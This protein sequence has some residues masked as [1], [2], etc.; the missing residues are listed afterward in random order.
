MSM[1]LYDFL[2]LTSNERLMHRYKVYLRSSTFK[3]KV[4]RLMS[5]MKC[6]DE[7][8]VVFPDFFF[9]NMMKMRLLFPGK[10]AHMILEE[11][12]R[13][14]T[15]K[16]LYQEKN[17]KVFNYE[18]LKADMQAMK[19]KMKVNKKIRELARF[20]MPPRL[21]QKIMFSVPGR[22][23]AQMKVMSVASELNV[24]ENMLSRHKML[25]TPRFKTDS[26]KTMT[27]ESLKND[28]HI[29]NLFLFCE[30]VFHKSRR[31]PKAEL[32]SIS[33]DFRKSIREKIGVELSYKKM[34]FWCRARHNIFAEI[35]IS[36][37]NWEMP[38][39]LDFSPPDRFSYYGVDSQKT[40]DYIVDMGA[41]YLLLDF[42]VTSSTTNFVRNKK[43]IKYK[44]LGEGLSRH[45]NKE[46]RV[47][48]VVWNI[49]ERN[50]FSLPTELRMIRRSL[51]TNLNLE[52]LYR[53]HLNIS[54]MENYDKY[55]KMSEEEDEEDYKDLER[56]IEAYKA[57]LGSS[58]SMVP[59][60]G[61]TK[62]PDL[63]HSRTLKENVPKNKRYIN[64][65][66]QNYLNEM[67]REV[68]DRDNAAKNSEEDQYL[69][70]TIKLML[71]MNN[72]KEV[73]IPKHMSAVLTL[74]K[75]SLVM[76]G[77]K[78]LKNQEEIRKSLP[79]GYKIPKLFKFPMVNVSSSKMEE[80]F[81]SRTID[82]FGAD[83][84][85]DDGTYYYKWTPGWK[86]QKE[87]EE[88]KRGKDYN[89]NGIGIDLEKD[90]KLIDNLM[91]EMSEEYQMKPGSIM[92]CLRFLDSE[93]NLSHIRNTK[94]WMILTFV[95]DLYM[96]LAL[97]SGRRDVFYYKRFSNKTHV[98]RSKSY[99]VMKRFGEYILMVKSGSHMTSN[100]VVRYKVIT[101]KDNVM[102]SEAF[103]KAFHTFREADFST[104][105]M[106]TKW[107]SCSVTDI[108]HFLKMKEVSVALMSN[109]R[110]KE[111]ENKKAGYLTFEPLRKRVLFMVVAL[112]EKSRNTSTAGQLNRYLM[113]SS[114]SYMSN[115]KEL[116]ND[117]FSE[118]IRTRVCSVLK[119]R[120]LQWYSLMLSK[121]EKMWYHR[122]ETQKS[123]SG[124]YDR[125]MMPSMFDLEDE[126]EFSVMMDEI[127]TCN[128]FD[129]DSGFRDHRMKSIVEK[130]TVAEL[131]YRKISQKLESQGKI[132]DRRQFL[133]DKDTLHTFDSRFVVAATNRFFR[134][135]VNKVKMQECLIRAMYS[136]I[137]SA[138]MMTSSLVGAAYE[139]DVM[140]FTEKLKKT[141]SF[142]SL[143]ALLKETPS[144]ML[145]DLC[146]NMD[147]VEA[148]F[149]IFP[150]AQIG[151]PREILIQSVMLRIMVKALETVSKEMSKTHDKEM[152]TKQHMRT[153]YQS[154]TLTHYKDL[155]RS[156]AEK[157]V[158]SI[159]F[160][161][162]ID[163]SKWAPGFVME[164]FLIFVHKWDIPSEMKDMIMSVLCAFSQK[165]MFVPEDMMVKWR[166]TDQNQV[167][168]QEGVQ[169]FKEWAKKGNGTVTIFLH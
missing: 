129:K 67:L 50:D 13:R 19:D 2:E 157:N 99:T 169:A 105:M 1:N 81:S 115:R 120:Q 113:H 103:S 141:K 55:R 44:D 66:D 31:I 166:K 143:F 87:E 131:K 119:L 29:N 139:S 3:V 39:E 43:V 164:H 58:I 95:S 62:A 47:S 68:D 135:K 93:E 90:P 107:L 33:M 125:L 150:K 9:I 146:N 127:Y 12:F 34:D 11:M 97:M 86:E 79:E 42:A 36:T 5:P 162:N 132:K 37:M 32:P 89:I 35:V 138:M 149:A 15:T 84:Y 145:M 8:V 167:E 142:L 64:K 117:I 152:L 77:T 16:F 91:E 156:L 123:F 82:F 49:N 163:S 100:K 158:P 134:N 88:R 28:Q 83:R 56:R 161:V 26:M 137:D 160:S 46:V 111:K 14:G 85:T 108:R 53:M 121:M 128:L 4:M 106:E 159:F 24:V 72:G 61:K 75:E 118:P 74:D 25:I 51:A 54:V 126:V 69:Q 96:N 21:Y 151:G 168:F 22:S 109:F 6:Y 94:L 153:V 76:E 155:S 104:D 38:E 165:K 23:M 144:H 133:L 92:D 48:A 110:D 65:E 148:L 17:S 102:A 130:M 78:L 114:L 59:N 45:L 40:P 52:F 57:L 122:I 140:A 70:E 124:D 73:E 20:S 112:L 154:D 136:V 147:K 98:V 116:L 63:E 101:H 10:E 27:E 41:Y 7:D 18:E 80:E 30:N 71:D 60:L